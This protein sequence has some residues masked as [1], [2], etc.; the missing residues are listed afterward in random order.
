ME[1][2]GGESERAMEKKRKIVLIR[3]YE[4][5]KDFFCWTCVLF[6]MAADAACKL[7]GI[8]DV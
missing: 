7:S 4:R 8:Y 2:Q 1:G 3:L 6:R 5:E